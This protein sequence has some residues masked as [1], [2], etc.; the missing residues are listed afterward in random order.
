MAHPGAQDSTNALYRLGQATASLVQVACSSPQS[1]PMR[2]WGR[3]SRLQLVG[4][5]VQGSAL[6]HKAHGTL[7]RPAE[8][9]R[10]LCRMCSPVRDGHAKSNLPALDIIMALLTSA[11]SQDAALEQ[12][13][14][15]GEITSKRMEHSHSNG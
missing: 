5:A 9:E 11:R 13:D 15:A 2:G 6:D 12:I 8:R 3:A 7:K 4:R 14:L 10:A 1:A